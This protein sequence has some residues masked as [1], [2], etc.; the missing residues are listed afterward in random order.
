MRKTCL[1]Q[2]L[3]LFKCEKPKEK[4][5]PWS[6]PFSNQPLYFWKK[7]HLC[8]HRSP[9]VFRSQCLLLFLLRIIFNKHSEIKKKIHIIALCSV[10][11][12]KGN[13]RPRFSAESNLTHPQTNKTKQHTPSRIAHCGRIGRSIVQTLIS[14]NWR[15]WATTPGGE[16]GEQ[17][18]EA[19]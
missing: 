8:L 9:G 2:K 3:P 14:S 11:H 17:E 5:F 15:C 1:E 4:T 19:W 18:K 10:S 16:R 13:R 12:N 6:N 7:N